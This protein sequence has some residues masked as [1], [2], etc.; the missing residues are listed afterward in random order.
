MENFEWY[1]VVALW[2][3]VT[4]VFGVM[5]IYLFSQEPLAWVV[6]IISGGLSYIFYRIARR[7]Y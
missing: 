5:Q 3:G 7:I 1:C 4:L 6:S 2:T